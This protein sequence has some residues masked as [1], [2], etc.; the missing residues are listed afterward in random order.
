MTMI[1]LY[2]LTACLSLASMTLPAQ[3][4]DSPY[5]MFGDTTRTLDCR[6]H[7]RK[8][9]QFILEHSQRSYWARRIVLEKTKSKNDGGL[10]YEKG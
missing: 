10:A 4:N 9:K 2:I 8:V 7:K 1:R 5:A 6:H 3:E